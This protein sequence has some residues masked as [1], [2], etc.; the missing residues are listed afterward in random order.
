MQAI[1]L[2]RVNVPTAGTPV[3]LSSLLTPAQLAMLPPTK[4]VAII[5]IWPDPAAV[6]KVY[7]KCQAPGQ[8]IGI[9][10]SLPVPTGG[11]PVPWQSNGDCSRNSINYAQFSLDA[12]TNNDGAFV[13]LWIE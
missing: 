2:G 3:L 7:V 9:I 6:G 10:A 8:P 5:D 11:Y 12:I 1:V 4:Q 13:T